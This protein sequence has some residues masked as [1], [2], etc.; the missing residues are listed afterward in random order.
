MLRDHAKN[1]KGILGKLRPLIEEFR[2]R[3]EAA[4]SHASESSVFEFNR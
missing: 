2:R 3:K 4:Q 1:V